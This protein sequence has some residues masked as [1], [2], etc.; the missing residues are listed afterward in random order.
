MG[1]NYILFLM[2]ALV[3]IIFS[4]VSSHWLIFWFWMEMSFLMFIPIITMSDEV[5]AKQSAMKYF[6]IQTFASIILLLVGYLYFEMLNTSFYTSIAMVSLLS[7]KLG[8]F[9]GHFWVIS[10]V[11]SMDLKKCLLVLGPMKI[12][13]TVILC[14]MVSMSP[15]TNTVLMVMGMLSIILGGVLGNNQTKM[16]TILGASSISH[17]GWMLL[18]VCFKSVWYYMAIYFL[19]LFSLFVGFI[20]F[21]KTLVGMSLFFM[22][23]VP[24]FSLF[25]GKILIL[26]DLIKSQ[27]FLISAGVVLGALFSM[28]FY[29]KFFYFFLLSRGLKF[30]SSLFLVLNCLG[31]VILFAFPF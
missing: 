22:S 2:V 15:D 5:E 7:I 21:K 31:F 3:S 25:F 14:E 29:L 26:V 8:V 24:P 1:F 28:I 30:D 27:M 20:S 16:H 6:S 9:P 19:A 10:T 17:G 11:G 12:L 23:G 13:P 18:G 4:L